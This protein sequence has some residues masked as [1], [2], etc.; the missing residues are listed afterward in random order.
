MAG[1]VITIAQRKGGAGKTTLA[2]Q[3]AVAWLE[4]GTRVAVLD[5]DPQASLAAWV[6][7]RRARLGGGAIGF[8]FAA[9]SGSRVAR[10][11][12]HMSA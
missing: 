3:L 10:H 1:R 8:A 7:L 9:L 6:G 4:A 5:I 2:A 12:D 11:L